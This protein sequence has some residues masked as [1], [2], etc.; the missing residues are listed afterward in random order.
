MILLG[1][2]YYWTRQL[3]AEQLNALGVRTGD[4]VMVHA[5]MRSVGPL[6]NGPDTLIDAL[7]DSLGP[8]GTLLCYVNWEQQYE[9][10]LDEQGGLPNFLK[11]A[12]PPFDPARSRASRDHGAFAESVRTTPGAE[13]SHN[14]GASVAAI[15]G[16]AAWFTADHP[17]DYGYGPGS[18]FAKFV[19]TSGK[20]LMIGAPLD[21][22]SLLHH[23]EHLAQIPGKHVRR[24]EVPLLLNGQVVWRMIEE[25]DTADPVVDGLD[26]DYFGAIA[27]DFL[28]TG[29]GQQGLI[30]HA[31]SAIFPAAG[32]V[33]F[34]VRWLDEQ[35]GQFPSAR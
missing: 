27:N 17:L 30:G 1:D 25:F 16:K 11:P 18:P 13:R 2:T 7:L 6:V 26:D 19:A 34:A 23:A 35:C 4:A 29:Q 28:A 12:I 14:P 24:M 10:A 3:L 9:D 15:G 33:D 8:D 5:G 32:L 31:P 21:T 22:I 20:V